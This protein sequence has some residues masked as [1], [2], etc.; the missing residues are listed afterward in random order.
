M[1]PLAYGDGNSFSTIAYLGG[2]DVDS[3]GGVSG[4]CM[5]YSAFGYAYYYP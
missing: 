4:Y 1:L 5:M 2:Y 3:S